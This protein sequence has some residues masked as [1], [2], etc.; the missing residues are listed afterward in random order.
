MSIFYLAC[1]AEGTG[2][3]LALSETQKKFFSRRGST[4]LGQIFQVQQIII[5]N[6][7]IEGAV[8]QIY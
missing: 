2:L 3:R 6:K 5:L 7:Y 1:F 8:L 4:A